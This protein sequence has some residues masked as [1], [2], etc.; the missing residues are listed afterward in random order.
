MVVKVKKINSYNLEVYT[1]VD[2]DKIIGID[3]INSPSSVS[4]QPYIKYQTFKIHFDNVDW[5][6][7]SSCYDSL[8]RAWLLAKNGKVE[9]IN[10]CTNLKEE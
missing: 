1:Y 10:L 5:E 9:D 8:L 4:V 2:V 7:D 6:I 3:D